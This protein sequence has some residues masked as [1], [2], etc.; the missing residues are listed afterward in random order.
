[1]NKE[2]QVE[3]D[4]IIDLIMT[5]KDKHLHIQELHAIR[6]VNP[7]INLDNYVSKALS[8]F[9]K[10]IQNE[11]TKLS[12]EE[13]ESVQVEDAAAVVGN[14]GSNDENKKPTSSILGLT[15]VKDS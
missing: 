10:S 9:Q 15:N 1:M 5:A 11:L 3:V 2:L 4:S 6:K 7:H 14:G 12:D 8:I 13:K